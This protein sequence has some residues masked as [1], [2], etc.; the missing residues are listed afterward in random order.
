VPL[1]G[2]LVRDGSEARAKRPYP[3]GTGITRPKTTRGRHREAGARSVP[4]FSTLRAKQLWPLSDQRR[5]SSIRLE[6]VKRGKVLTERFQHAH[7]YP[8]RRTEPCAPRR[9]RRVQ[10]L[11]FAAEVGVTDAGKPADGG[12]ENR[13]PTC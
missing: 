12:S 8:C 11:T 2:G 9:R 13:L 7:D 5:I 3:S 6:S 10:E 1:A 4:S